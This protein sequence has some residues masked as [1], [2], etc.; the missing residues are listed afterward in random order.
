MRT[1]RCSLCKRKGCETFRTEAG[2]NGEH[3]V[4]VNICAKH[5]KDFLK[6]ENAFIN[7]NQSRFDDM[8][9]EQEAME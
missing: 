7:R 5:L 9:I 8:V 1:D 2:N 3:L 6:D 4:W